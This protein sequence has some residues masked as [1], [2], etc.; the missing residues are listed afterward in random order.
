[1]YFCFSI[2]QHNE[3]FPDLF[4]L[5]KAKGNKVLA[6]FVVTQCHYVFFDLVGTGG[7]SPQ[8]KMCVRAL[9]P[10]FWGIY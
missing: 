1:M 7:F 2:P 9:L 3:L 5:A 8:V 10:L 4:F 6:I